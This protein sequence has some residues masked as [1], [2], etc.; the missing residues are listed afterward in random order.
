MW[1]GVGLRSSQQNN[2]KLRSDG[3]SILS[4]NQV[5]QWDIPILN[6]TLIHGPDWENVYCK[7]SL[8][9]ARALEFTTVNIPVQSLPWV[10]H[11]FSLATVRT[12]A[13]D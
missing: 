10:V 1:D 8:P 13:T 12:P 5:W 2:Q 6:H 7:V 4:G 3:V 9:K 11:L